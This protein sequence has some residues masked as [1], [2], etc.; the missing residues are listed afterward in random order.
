MRRAA[1]PPRCEEPAAVAQV[2][3]QDGRLSDEVFHIPTVGHLNEEPRQAGG[4]VSRLVW[5]HLGR[6]KSGY[7]C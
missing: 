2:S 4:T 1:A 3:D 7:L 6:G 5:R